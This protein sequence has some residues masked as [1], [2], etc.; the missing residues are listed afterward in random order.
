MAGSLVRRVSAKT[1][2]V[3]WQAKLY[4]DGDWETATFALRKEAKD[5]LQR[6]QDEAKLP[7]STETIGGYLDHWVETVKRHTVKPSTFRSY[8]WQ[9]KTQIRPTL[10]AIR[11]QDLKATAAQSWISAQKDRVSEKTK[12]PISARMVRYSY[13]ILHGA[14]AHALGAGLVKKNVW[15]AVTPPRK[16]PQRH[17]TWD[18]AQVLTFLDAA[19]FETYS[20]IWRLA[21]TSGMRLGELLGLRWQDVDLDTGTIRVAQGVVLWE[22]GNHM[23]SPKSAAGIRTIRI[24][25][26]TV[27]ALKRLVTATKTQSLKKGA[28]WKESGLV[29]VSN[30]GT[31]I[32]D[33]NLRKV[34]I[35]IINSAGLPY[36][37]IHDLR[38][39]SA[40]IAVQNG[41]PYNTV[42]A[43]LGHADIRTTLGF[44][45][46]S[47]DTDDAQA[48]D[49]IEALM[50][51]QQRA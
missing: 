34:Y 19:E 24:G 41:V 21:L 5:A 18:E 4:R 49:T 35:R 16:D 20:P 22:D 33:D 14:F 38:H 40:T 39:T 1:G 28:A 10:G 6:W 25:P 2:K 11:L 50:S 36:I 45:V 23:D 46:R 9:I 37:R 51:R 44:Y 48:A 27:A 29:F 8:R 13:T 32:N 43:R 17:V 12:A 30:V 7:P 47:R 31:A 42:S 3:S 26:L 15:D